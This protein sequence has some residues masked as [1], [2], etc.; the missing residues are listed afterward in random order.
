MKKINFDKEEK[1]FKKELD[2]GKFKIERP[3]NNTQ[4]DYQ[5]YEDRDLAAFKDY[6]QSE[7]FAA[8]KAGT[9]NC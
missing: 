3:T 8:L 6:L 4:R 5:D 7:A 9:Q 1:D 2:E